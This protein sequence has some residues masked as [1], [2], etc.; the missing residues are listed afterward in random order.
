M[1]ELKVGY[2]KYFNKKYKRTGPLWRDRFKSLLIEDENY[3]YACGLYIEYNP[4]KAGI[5]EKAEDWSCSSSAYYFLGKED[6]LIDPY[7]R[8]NL[9]EDIDIGDER[10]FTKGR[11]IGSELFR[12]QLEDKALPVP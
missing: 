12:I 3:L 10:F 11:G 9:P 2:T 1:K 5:V 7:D 4:V 6:S 8:D